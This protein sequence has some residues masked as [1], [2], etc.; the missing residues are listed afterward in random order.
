MNPAYSSRLKDQVP[1]LVT[2][3][4]LV[5]G[6]V[7][8]IMVFSGEM[9]LASWLIIL[10]ALFDFMDGFAAR[11]LNARS[12]IGA[13]LD[14]LADVISFGLAPAA[15][16]FQLI[17]QNPGNNPVAAGGLPLLPFAGLLL[18]VAGAWRLARFN[19]VPGQSVIFKGLPIPATGLFVAS[20][21]LMI[22]QMRAASILT[23][24][25]ENRFTLIA[26]ILLLSWLMVSSIPMMSLKFKNL[27]WK[28]NTYQF[29]LVGS[30]PL[31]F[32][33]LRF[34]A[35]PLVIILYL[36]L[37]LISLSNKSRLSGN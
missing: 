11:L 9:I 12:S 18:V 26:V 35:I 21:P 30:V 1:N 23:G 13:Q 19:S 16:M 28:D 27:I 32:V 4:N 22:N 36:I 31:L 37:S 17:L 20:L 29:I 5:C 14:S 10:A 8:I 7:A 25:I 6:S 2:L 15:V 24:F 3:L 33:F 34:A